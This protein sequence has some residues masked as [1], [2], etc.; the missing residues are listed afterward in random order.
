MLPFRR[1]GSFGSGWTPAFAGVTRRDSMTTPR[2]LI[3]AGSDSG[4]GAGIQADIKTVTMLGG[5]ATPALT[6]ITAQTTTRVGAGPGGGPAIQADTR[7]APRP[8]GPATTAITAITAQ[9]TF[10]VDA[11]MPVPAE[12]VLKQ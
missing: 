6:A 2:I 3:I 8:G 5:H 1:C 9:N 10:G 7:P 4:G 12:M 11:V